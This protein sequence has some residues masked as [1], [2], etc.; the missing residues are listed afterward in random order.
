MEENK[1]LEEE[2]LKTDKKESEEEEDLDAPFENLEEIKRKKLIG[3]DE[4]LSVTQKLS[5]IE[6]NLLR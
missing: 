6:K 4:S 1:K 2:K 5:D 3:A